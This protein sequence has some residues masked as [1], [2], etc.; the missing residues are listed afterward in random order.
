MP[1]IREATVADAPAI[2]A[3]IVELAQSMCETS[4]MTPAYV[5]TYLTFPGCNILVAEEHG[6]VAGLLS[7]SVRPNLYHNGPTALI[8]ELVVTSTWRGQGIG[9]AM[10]EELL[11]RLESAG[12]EEVS[13][14]TLVN[15]EGAI[16]F[17]RAH[18]LVDEAIYLE[19]HL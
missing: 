16:R 15:N 8:E 18:G 2:A 5:N 12:C 17:Y 13:V 6:Q 3:L 10:L 9:G 14:T 19:K 7:Y 1:T 11:S 4:P